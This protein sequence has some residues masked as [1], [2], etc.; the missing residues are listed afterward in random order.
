M[1]LPGS[2]GLGDAV[3]VTLR[4]NCPAVATVT[5]VVAVFVSGSGSVTLEVIFAVSET[6]VPDGVDEFTL[7]TIV[8]VAVPPEAKVAIVP[9]TVPVPPT[10]GV[11]QLHAPLAH[12]SDP[13][14]A[15]TGGGVVGMTGITSV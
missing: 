14:V 3:L 13:N 15:Y 6:T 2:T 10:E 1:L 9:V 8:N 12:V 11:V 5:L 7:S 4:S